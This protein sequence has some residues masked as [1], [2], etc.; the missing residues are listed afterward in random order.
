MTEI[1]LSA[2]VF[3]RGPA[4]QAADLRHFG[5]NRAQNAPRGAL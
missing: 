1:A 2:M 4:L 3:S 5:T